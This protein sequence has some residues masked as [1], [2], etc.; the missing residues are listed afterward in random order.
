MAILI[1]D[2]ADFKLKN[3]KRQKRTLYVNKRFNTAGKYKM[4]IYIPNDRS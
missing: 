4:N 2:K 3:Y 1:L